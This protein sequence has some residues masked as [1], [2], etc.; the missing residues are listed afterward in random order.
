MSCLD[1]FQLG[2]VIYGP[3]CCC[4]A[5]RSGLTAT[6]QISHFCATSAHTEPSEAL[7]PITGLLN[8]ENAIV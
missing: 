6:N 2:L 7:R 8:C 3:F 1:C 4:Y 5:N